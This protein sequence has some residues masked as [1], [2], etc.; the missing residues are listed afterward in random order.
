MN[1][2][3]ASLAKTQRS[4]KSA[5]KNMCRSGFSLASL[6]ALRASLRLCVRL[7]PLFFI[8]GTALAAEPTAPAPGANMQLDTTDI[9]AHR[10]LPKVMTIVP[11]KRADGGDLPGRPA[12]SLLDEVLAPVD[13]GEFRRQLRYTQQLDDAAAP[14]SKP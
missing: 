12:A 6:C 7:L 11:W 14:A 10:G 2:K 13:R 1:L 4:A 8:G 5:K 3:K 9:N